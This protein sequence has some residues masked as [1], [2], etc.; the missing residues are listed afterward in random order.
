MA[1]TTCMFPMFYMHGD[2]VSTTFVISVKTTPIM[3]DRFT[4]VNFPKNVD[5]AAI[6]SA[7]DHLNN[8]MTPQVSC[9]VS[10]EFIGG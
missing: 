10:G 2:G 7:R 4:V 6:V 1:I 9:T 3:F 5:V 8:D